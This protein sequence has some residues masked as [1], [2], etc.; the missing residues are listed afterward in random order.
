M[1]LSHQMHFAVL[2]SAT[3]CSLLHAMYQVAAFAV[4]QQACCSL[5][6][7][8]ASTCAVLL[9]LFHDDFQMFAALCFASHGMI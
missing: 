9:L 3:C 5:L 4:A 6:C 8:G 2:L 1:L 7:Y